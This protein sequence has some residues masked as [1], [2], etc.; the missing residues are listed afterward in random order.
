MK[1]ECQELHGLSPAIEEKY[2]EKHTESIPK[3]PEMSILKEI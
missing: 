3:Y 1:F 2:F